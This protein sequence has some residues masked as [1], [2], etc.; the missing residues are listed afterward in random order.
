MVSVVALLAMA[1]YLQLSFKNNERIISE[2]T[3][4]VIESSGSTYVSGFFEEVDFFSQ[5]KLDREIS[6]SKT[7]VAIHDLLASS[8]I[9]ADLEDK[10]EEKLNRLVTVAEAET[11]IETLVNEKGYKEVFVAIG[12]DGS[13]DIVVNAPSLSQ[14]EVSQIADIASRHANIPIQNI[15]IKNKF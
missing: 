15:H 3:R 5:A 6:Q 9:T 12:E 13:M 2:S 11:K 7:K 1:F 14:S 8:N 4:D 10:V